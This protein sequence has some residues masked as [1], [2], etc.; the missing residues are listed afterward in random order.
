MKLSWLIVATFVVGLSIGLAVGHWNNEFRHGSSP[1][2]LSERS[3]ATFSFVVRSTSSGGRGF[4]EP[5][6]DVNAAAQRVPTFPTEYPVSRIW[7]NSREVR[8]R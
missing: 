3:E 7:P 4:E 1:S 8:Q 6:A 2:P 5:D